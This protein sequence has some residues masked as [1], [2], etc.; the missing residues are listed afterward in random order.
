MDVQPTNFPSQVL[1]ENTLFE[2]NAAI[3]GCGGAIR[4]EQDM[5]EVTVSNSTFDRNTATRGPGGAICSNIG[6]TVKVRDSKFD[7]NLA[8]EGGAIV[9]SA[10][11]KV[12]VESGQIHNS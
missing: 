9:V 5:A 11:S 1:I 3:E 6:T 12:E 8:A 2:R 7:S 10:H 4:S